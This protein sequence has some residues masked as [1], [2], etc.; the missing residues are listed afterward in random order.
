MT[1]SG[2]LF[3]GDNLEVLRRHISDESVDLVY[4]DPP[5]NSNADYNVLFAEQDGSRSAAQV[6]AFEDTWRWDQCAAAALDEVVE[7]GDEVART[8][9]AF[10]TILGESNMLAY[11]AMM[12]PRLVELHRAMRP[13]GSLYLHCDPTASHYLKLLLDAIFG[14]TNFRS[15]IVWKRSSAHSDT[16]QGRRIHGHIHDVL[17]FFT[18]GSEWIWN[19]VYTPYD[20]SYVDGF[21]KHIESATGRRYRLGDL[22]AAKPGGDV[23]YEWHGRFPYKGRYWAYS[24]DKMDAMFE[25]GRIYIPRK[26]DGVPS[27]KRYL[28]EMPGVPLQDLWTDLDPIHASAAERL[29]YPTQ[30]PETLLERIIE[31]SSCE[32]SVILDPFCGCGTAVAVAEKLGR[33][34]IGIDVTYLATHLIKNRLVEAFGESV[35]FTV[36]GEPTTPED[37]AKLAIED[38]FQFEAWALGLVGARSASKKRGPD[39]GIDGRLV[40]HEKR[41]GKTREGLFSV[42]SGRTGVKDVRDLRGVI[43]REGAE[44]GVLIT[45]RAPTQAM[46]TEA[47]TAGFYRSGSEGVGTWGKHPRIQLLTISELLEGRRV[48]MPPLSGSLNFKRS[49]KVE[50]RRHIAEPLFRNLDPGSDIAGNLRSE[51]PGR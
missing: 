18:K 42:K 49:P 36:T 47:T 51:I 9:R 2:A 48:D 37:A 41:G 40:F 25:E 21:Y 11:L 17:L 27:Y 35:D 30:K 44:I 45:L 34:W 1:Q 50:R 22:T 14:P 32:D 43:E 38:P 10:R 28:D 3:Y 6:K 19:P 33:A 39:K 26:P 7:Q 31:S 23:S 24:R 46:R 12:A 5:F 4:L 8:M 29:G 16:K 15:E 20:Q 13:T